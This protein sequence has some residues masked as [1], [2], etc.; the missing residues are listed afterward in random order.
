MEFGLR[1]GSL[2]VWLYQ[3]LNSGI[4]LLIW[5]YITWLIVYAIKCQYSFDMS[6]AYGLTSVGSVFLVNAG[7]YCC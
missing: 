3:L 7:Y 2:T 1:I 6:I 4:V 5:S